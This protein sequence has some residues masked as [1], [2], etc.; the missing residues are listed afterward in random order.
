M[1]VGIVTFHCAYN[2]GS[3]L[4]AWA[5]LRTLGTRGHEAHVVDYRGRDFDQY[6][7]IQTFSPKAFLASLA[8]Y[9]SNRR[10]RDS[11][12]RF[13]AERLVP[14]ARYG[15]DDEARMAAELPERFD[16]FVCGSDQIW[17]LDCT[18][19]PVGPYFLSFAGGVRR[20][21]YAPSLSHT[22]FASENFGPAQ[23]EQ[24]ACWLSR[25]SAVSVREAST[26]P[27]FQPLCPVPIETCLDPTLLLD[28]ADYDAITTPVTEA[29]DT[30]L[31]YM[32]EKNPELVAYAARLARE[33]G[34]SVSYV[35]KHRLD[36]G[37]PAR[38]YYGVGPSEFLGLVRGCSA[39]VTNSFHATVFSLLFGVPFQT[40]VTERS[41]S[42]MRELLAELGQESHLV[43][44]S[45]LTVPTAVPPEVLAPRLE[46]LRASSL[47]FL[48]RALAE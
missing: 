19:G 45:V 36:F 5:L 28:A 40:F 11:F 43:D 29:K 10:R 15:V 25:F 26:A 31:V 32:L 20:V 23:R 3:A 2:F 44:G 38:N 42:R 4:Q 34:V 13:I 24:I 33:T 37:V 39:V 18:C 12:E 48:D 9:G 7:L 17:N 41:G 21:A 8:F 46:K 14:T 16:C 6:R 30:L 22:A 27:L 1:R 47:A 35:S